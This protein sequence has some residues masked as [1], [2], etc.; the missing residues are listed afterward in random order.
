MSD[1]VRKRF[2]ETAE[3]VAQQQ[4]RRPAATQERLRHLLTLTGE[5]R[6]L[7]IGTGAGAFAIALAPLVSQSSRT[8]TR[9]CAARSS[10][11]PSCARGRVLRLGDDTAD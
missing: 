7:N 6:A 5:E 4:D 11:L 3:L 1:A 9:A 2:G 10:S 8:T